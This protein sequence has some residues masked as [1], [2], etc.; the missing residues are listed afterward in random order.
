[1]AGL[2]LVK[3][4]LDLFGGFRCRESGV[5]NASVDLL[6]AEIV[7]ARVMPRTLAVS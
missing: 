6:E 1:M 4:D 3:I 5:V 7:R 2:P